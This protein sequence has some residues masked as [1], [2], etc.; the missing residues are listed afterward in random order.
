VCFLLQWIESSY[1]GGGGGRGS[2]GGGGGGG[3]S[4]VVGRTRWWFFVEV[5]KWILLWR[6]ECYVYSFFIEN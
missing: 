6:K 4:R 5:R 3:E 1:G 2:G